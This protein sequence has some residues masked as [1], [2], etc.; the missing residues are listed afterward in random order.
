MNC[1]IFIDYFLFD[2]N[3]KKPF[4]QLDYREDYAT[5]FIGLTMQKFR[6][7]FGSK[8]KNNYKP[9][10]VHC[11]LRSHNDQWKEL[12]EEYRTELEMPDNDIKK[13]IK[14]AVVKSFNTEA[15]G[16]ESF[17][18]FIEDEEFRL[19]PH[20]NFIPGEHKI[21]N[22]DRDEQLARQRL[23]HNMSKE[24]MEEAYKKIQ[25]RRKEKQ[26]RMSRNK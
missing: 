10:S 24:N 11:M 8:A 7:S 5:I 1:N 3:N 2:I 25:E 6:K 14:H 23:E 20:F 17:T 9:G 13:A 16:L 4:E 19:V 18:D 26:A 15:E 12:I 22:D 21:F